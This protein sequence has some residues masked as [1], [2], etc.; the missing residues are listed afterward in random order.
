MKYILLICLLLGG[1]IKKIIQK[2]QEIAEKASPEQE[3]NVLYISDELQKLDVYGPLLWFSII[4]GSV[5]LLALSSKL[6]KNE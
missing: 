3:N 5:M 4:I 2:P 6:F 1:C